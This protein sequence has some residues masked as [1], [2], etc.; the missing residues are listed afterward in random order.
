MES[1]RG[2]EKILIA[3]PLYPPEIGGP[4]TYVKMLEAELPQHGFTLTVV[5]FSALRTYPKVLRHL[6]YTF[7]LLKKAW[8]KDMIYALDPVS[9]G[10]PAKVASVITR[11]RFWVRLGGDYAWEQGQQRFGLTQMLD[12][13]T[14]KKNEAPWQVRALAA[15]QS[16]VV[17]GAQKVVV[18]SKYMSR[19]V[20]TW[21]TA[22]EQLAV[23]YS[24]LHPLPVPLDK[25]DYRRKFGFSGPVVLSAGRL[26]PW[27]GFKELIDVVDQLRKQ[28]SDIKLLIAGDGP[29]KGE[30]HE[31]IAEKGLS[32]CVQLLGRLPKE[33]LG[34]YIKAADLFVLNT[35]YEGLSHQLLEV[36]ALETPV[37][38]TDVGGNPELIEGGVSGYLVALGDTQQLRARMH[39]LL[40]DAQL[41]Q[42]FAQK[43]RSRTE[44]FTSEKSVESLIN[45]L[46]S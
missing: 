4:A 46:R 15:V 9:V 45:L 21:G 24:A 17:R 44:L 10:L 35:A 39:T 2:I 8:G 37:V 34:Q 43:A 20:S 6:I 40:S 42:N 23:V 3:A 26:V 16:F 1:K 25:K 11:K 28:H 36:M 30:L 14:Q 13:Y 33:E 38:A 12:E 27:K 19:I 18:P 7:L 41:Q 22:E 5:P 32:S 29:T 31:Y